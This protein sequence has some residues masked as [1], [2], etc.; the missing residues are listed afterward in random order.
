LLLW[1]EQCVPAADAVIR[2]FI[3]HGDRTDRKKARLKYLLDRWGHEK[4][5]D[6]AIK[7]MPFT[8]AKLPLDK[9]ELPRPEDRSG[10]LGVHRQK[11][12]GLCYVGVAVPVGRLSIEQMHGLASIAERWGSGTI[13]LT[14]WQN[15]IIS[16]V[17]E[18]DV[19]A[20]QREIVGLKLAWSANAFQAGLIACTGNTGCKYSATN[21]KGHALAIA[22]HLESRFELDSPINIHLTGCHH[23]CA[24]HYIGDVGL[25]GTKVSQGEDMVEGY[26]VY[27]G[28]GSGDRQGIAREFA[29]DV[30]FEAAPPMLERI[31]RLYLDRRDDGETFHAFTNRHSLEQIRSW[32]E[33]TEAVS[34]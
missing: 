8:P 2:V 5:L 16:D 26:H 6:E 27:L 21:T 22:E 31:L 19:E 14:V 12:D 7:E 11:Q 18:K 20:V 34:A 33:Q 28:G 23:S 30:P 24:Q 9:C 3:A 32:Y 1:P 10:H 25:L 4:F 15:L 13:R 17:A 29:R